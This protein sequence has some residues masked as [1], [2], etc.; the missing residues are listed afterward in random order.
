MEGSVARKEDPF[1]YI[2]IVVA[3]VCVLVGLASKLELWGF[4]MS[5]NLFLILIGSLTGA[6]GISAIIQRRR[7]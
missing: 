3:G 6:L 4:E 1:F 5:N 2:A 7:K